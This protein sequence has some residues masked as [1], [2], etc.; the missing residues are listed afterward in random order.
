MDYFDL[1]S[2]I[3]TIIQLF[4]NSDTFALAILNIC[5]VAFHV[6]LEIYITPERS[7]WVIVSHIVQITSTCCLEK[8]RRNFSADSIDDTAAV[9]AL[10]NL[11]NNR[12]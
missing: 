2:D 12:S 9:F 6:G 4:T 8:A 5:F 3:L 7:C 11:F 1:V 10:F